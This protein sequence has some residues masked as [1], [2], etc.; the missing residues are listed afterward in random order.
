MDKKVKEGKIKFLEFET[1]Y[2]IVNPNGKKPPLLL[3]HGGPGSTH[4]YFESFDELAFKTDRPFIMYDQI[5]CGGSYISG[6][7]ELFT[8]E[9][10]M[11]EL[12]NLR[13]ELNLDVIHIL[14]QSWGGMLAI[15]YAL[16]RNPKGVRSYILSSTLS[17][18]KL[19]KEEQYRRIKFLPQHMQNAIKNAVEKEDY[20]NKEYLDAVDE[21]MERHCAS[22]VTE[23]SP[24]YLRRKKVAGTEAYLTGWGPNEFTPTG[25]L[26]DYEVTDLLKEIKT[27]CL[28]TNG[29][30]DL[31]S[32][33]ISK[34]MADN[35]ENSKWELFRTSR[36]MPFIEEKELYHV[37]LSNWLKE[38]DN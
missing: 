26:S 11:D 7:K 37:I 31:S 3:L 19:W 5:G 13:K 38:N 8:K 30:D 6:H 18:A 14:G 22:K 2:R 12:E 16:N 32:P 24:E 33:Y 34:T 29:Q 28:I 35:L 21:F 17:S 20:D 4:N 36:H 9:I 10:W 1:Y 15:L 23:A 25:T 27:P